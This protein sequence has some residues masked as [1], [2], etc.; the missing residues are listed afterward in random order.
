MKKSS[1]FYFVDMHYVE[2]VR[3]SWFWNTPHAPSPTTLRVSKTLGFRMSY[4]GNNSEPDSNSSNFS[5][6]K[7]P[8]IDGLVRRGAALP[9]APTVP[10]SSPTESKLGEADLPRA[11]LREAYSR[12]GPSRG[13][14]PGSGSQSYEPSRGRER[15]RGLEPPRW[16]GSSRGKLSRPGSSRGSGRGE[17]HA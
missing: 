5:E 17:R 6:G 16:S 3:Q 10:K 12:G 1:T 11:G 8:S 4:V 14:I 9:L 7:Y 13:V 15:S 2:R